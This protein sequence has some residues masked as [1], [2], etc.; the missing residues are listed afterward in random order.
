MKKILKEIEDLPKKDKIK[1]VEEKCKL[2][3][4][5]YWYEHEF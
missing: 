1:V 5:T 2:I 3:S 4:W